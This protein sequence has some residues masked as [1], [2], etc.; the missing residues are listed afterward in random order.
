VVTFPV[1]RHVVD[2]EGETW[3]EMGNLV[4][5]GPFKLVE[6]KQNNP[7]LFDRN[8][9]YHGLYN[10]N[11]ERVELSFPAGQEQN[12]LHLYE[13]ESFDFIDLRDLHPVD[14][15]RA[16][17]IHAGEYVSGP[18]LACYY[19]GFNVNNPPLNNILV[20]RALTLATSRERLANIAHQGFIFPATGS[21]VPSGMPG[22][23][24]NI[25]APY[26]PEQARALMS[27]AGYPDG[28]GFEGLKCLAADTPLN[29]TTADFLKAQWLQILGI[30]ITL[31]FV[32]WGKYLDLIHSKTQK[33]WISGFMIEYP[34]P[35]CVFRVEDVI[36]SSQWKNETF[37]D[38]VEEARR[39]M[40]QEAR[41]KL[42]QRA[43]RIVVEEAPVIPLAYGRSHMLV[44]PWVKK[45]ILSANNPLFWKDIVIDPH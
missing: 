40:D 29:R 25:A 39:I 18:S 14:A 27:E 35:D 4:T 16:R 15:D 42:Y 3:T 5:N 37:D 36:R 31:K 20:R 8:P 1:P 30:D 22:H 32:E 7:A 26:D 44:K 12:L 23:S 24:S 9:A 34:D 21:L 11:L 17:Q 33:L 45:L 10:G 38:L 19:V 28:H 6:W 2:V 13:K 41:M 43:D